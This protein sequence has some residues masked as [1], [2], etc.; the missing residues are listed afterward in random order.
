MHRLVVF[1]VSIIRIHT[2]SINARTEEV[3]FGIRNEQRI[4]RERLY[5]ASLQILQVCD[6]ILEY[7]QFYY[8]NCKYLASI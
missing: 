8:K 4:L 2:W 5:Y 6:T 7:F 3:Y 1:I